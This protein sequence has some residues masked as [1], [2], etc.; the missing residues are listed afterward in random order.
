M[1]DSAYSWDF[2]IIHSSADKQDAGELYK[3]L[4]PPYKVFLD[5]EVI[6][7]SDDYTRTLQ[8]GLRSSRVFVVLVSKHSDASPYC[9]DEI[10]TALDLCK[11][12]PQGRKIIPVWLVPRGTV[13]PPW[14]TAHIQSLELQAEGGMAAVA[15]RLRQLV[16]GAAPPPEPPKPAHVL[17]QYV[18]AYF[19]P[20][21]KVPRTL[22]AAY[23][24]RI[25]YTDALAVV[26][27]A[28]EFRRSAD[29]GDPTVTCIDK[30]AIP[31]PAPIP[32]GEFWRATF[33]EARLHGPRMLAALLLTVDAS[34]FAQQ[35]KND[36]QALLD[37]LRGLPQ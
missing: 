5:Q 36:R 29:P 11:K 28:N 13:D 19:I 17:H 1:S 22:A 3:L 27:E 25:H 15:A 26:D 20:S 10:V 18:R 9:R 8:A 21:E 4:S 16:D 31:T 2:F 35:A 14:G 12:D 32:Q 37:Y 7:P 24:D 30:T 6:R 34:H 23:A 33:R